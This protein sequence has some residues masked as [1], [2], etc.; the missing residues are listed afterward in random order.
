MRGLRTALPI[1]IARSRG[2][3]M[4]DGTSKTRSSGTAEL[5]PRA[6]VGARS[7]S[8]GLARSSTTLSLNSRRRGRALPDRQRRW[9]RSDAPEG[10]SP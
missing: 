9:R 1:N 8:L 4:I 10:Q 2:A 7:A 3:W 6:S 5:S